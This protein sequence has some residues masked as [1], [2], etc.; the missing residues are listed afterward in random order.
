MKTK[1]LGRIIMVL[2]L[3]AIG[4]LF[5]WY[6]YAQ[7]AIRTANANAVVWA[8]AQKVAEARV[9][10]LEANPIVKTEIATK[11]VEVEK[12]VEKPVEKIVEIKIPV[13]ETVTIKVPSADP[14][15]PTLKLDTPVLAS[16][17][18]PVV[19]APKLIA[20]VS[21]EG[22]NPTKV[23]S[24]QVG[25]GG[26]CWFYA[27]PGL[28]QTVK[29]SVKLLDDAAFAGD[30]DAIKVGDKMLG[31]QNDA[32]DVIVFGDSPGTY[33]FT[34]YSVGICVANQT[35]PPAGKADK[36]FNNRDYNGDG[37]SAY[38]LG[39]KGEVTKTR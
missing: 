15:T 35:Q 34:A 36:V 26:P 19:S 29:I 7:P 5:A 4:A 6:F 16:G 14:I 24:P 28:S 37:R 17:K 32:D 33:S 23:Y 13:T 1:T 39:P 8:D 18:A 25:D 10:Y 20:E 31:K 21:I 30:A 12:I 9:K 11:T 22:Q 38:W 27:G 3:L 2:A